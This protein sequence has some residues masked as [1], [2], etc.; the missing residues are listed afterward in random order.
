MAYSSDSD[1]KYSQD[2]IRF[3][4]TMGLTGETY[5]HKGW[6][7]YESVKKKHLYNPEIDNIASASDLNMCL[8][9]CLPG[10]RN[11]I[12]G[13]LQLGNKVGGFSQRDIK[14]VN[15]LSTILGFM[16]AGV[17]DISEALELTIKMKQ[18]LNA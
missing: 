14:V 5:K 13:I 12:S 7:V 8:M 18:H 1:L 11:G 3:P 9:S 16:V 2:K 6:V 4:I 17:N 10:P 15:G